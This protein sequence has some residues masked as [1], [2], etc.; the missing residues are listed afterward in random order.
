VVA[1]SGDSGNGGVIDVCS[2][3]VVVVLLLELFVVVGARS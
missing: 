3:V 1:S 2:G